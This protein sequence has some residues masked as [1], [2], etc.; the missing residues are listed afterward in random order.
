MSAGNMSRMPSALARVRLRWIVAGL[1][2]ALLTA[3]LLRGWLMTDYLD[4]DESQIYGIAA[5][6]LWAD[7]AREFRSRTHPPLAYL[8]MKP[9]LALSHEAWAVKAMSLLTGVAAIPIIQ[10]ALAERLSPASALLGAVVISTTPD[11]VWQSI[12]ARHYSLCLLLVWL[13]LLVYLRLERNASPRLKDHARLAFVL[14]LVL[15]TEYL[16]APHVVAVAGL[17][18]VPA[19][20]RHLLARRWGRAV[21]VVAIYVGTLGLPAALFVWQFQGGVPSRHPHTIPFMYAGSLLDV[22]AMLGFLVDR[23]LA[24]ADTLI[25]SPGGILLLVLLPVPWAGLLRGDPGERLAR[26]LSL[27]AVLALGFT[28]AGALLGHLPLGGR[29]RHT[30]AIVPLVLLADTFILAGLV[31]RLPRPA[32]RVAA[33]AVVAG[34]FLIGSAAGLRAGVNAGG[35]YAALASVGALGDYSQRPAAIIA[36]QRGRRL[37]SWWLLRG[38]EPRLVSVSPEGCLNFSYR[39][40]SQETS[41]IECYNGDA[42]VTRAR[43]LVRTEG[44]AWIV[45]TDQSD[46]MGLAEAMRHVV[47]ALAASPD[48]EVRSR[49]VTRWLLYVAVAEVQRTPSAGP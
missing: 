45:M 13:S 2:T 12:E 23:G 21:A 33:S 8:A 39:D 19:V 18:A 43:E 14:L 48:I 10:L 32:W 30:I 7:F 11:F 4:Y 35:G 26:R 41:V 1:L 37:A 28:A 6:P 29:A 24:F 42:L 3:A 47:A 31:A 46:A 5:S 22:R 20:R 25:P 38:R 34:G 27:G 17:A 15:L 44:R 16:A 9:F 49:A 40:T 36:D